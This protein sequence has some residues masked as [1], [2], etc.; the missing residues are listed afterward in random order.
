MGD[1]ELRKTVLNFICK[2]SS[3]VTSSRSAKHYLTL[4]SSGHCSKNVAKQ[5]KRKTTTKQ[6]QGLFAG[7]F[8]NL[9]KQVSWA[10]FEICPGQH[11]FWKRKFF[12]M[13]ILFFLV[14]AVLLSY[15]ISL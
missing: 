7:V 11:I 1:Y 2:F 13:T 10:E 9:R 3:Q 15:Q 14:H 12:V 6:Q 8:E 5:N 4:K